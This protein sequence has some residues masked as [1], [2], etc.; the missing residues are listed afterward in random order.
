MTACSSKHE[1]PTVKYKAVGFTCA[2][3]VAWLEIRTKDAK[4]ASNWGAD[5]AEGAIRMPTT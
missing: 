3:F 1:F 5:M 4:L 2:H